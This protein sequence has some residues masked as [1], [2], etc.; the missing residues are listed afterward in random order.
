MEPFKIVHI[1]DN[2]NDAAF[3][4][5]ALQKDTLPCLLVRVQTWNDLVQVLQTEEIDLILSD[6]S[7]PQFNG[8]QALELAHQ[9]RPEVPFIFVSGTIQESVAINSLEHGASNYIFKDRLCQLT[10]VVRQ[11]LVEGRER[12]QIG[13]M[14]AELQQTRKLASVATLSGGLVHDFRNLLQILKLNIALLPPSAFEPDEVVKLA[15]QLDKA[16]D[17][18]CDMMQEFMIYARKTE[19]NLVRVDLSKQIS[20]TVTTF[21]PALPP[22]VSICTA[23]MISPP[24]I[25]GDVGQIDRIVTNLLRNAVDA[26]PPEGGVITIKSDLVR[27]EP[28]PTDPAP[29][30]DVP[31]LRVVITDNGLGMSPETR[32]RIFE[33]F[34]TTKAAGKGTG[35]GLPMVLG[36][37]EG[38]KGF[39]D[40]QS[41]VGKGTSFILFFP[42][43]K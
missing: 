19:S 34:F 21:R 7:L 30:A 16:T 39:I 24:S 42:M 25:L 38:H 36:L 37:M 17:R 1:E 4:E 3:I 2:D 14:A 33:P 28:L 12:K 5:R 22:S 13:E 40:L 8:L 18:G 43:A 29:I 6:Y 41:E 35:L 9:Q 26:M 31:Y 32:A 20:E 11:V 10:P 15:R 23:L 27:I